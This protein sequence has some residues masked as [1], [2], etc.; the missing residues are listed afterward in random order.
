MLVPSS[1]AAGGA[2]AP[3]PEAEDDDD[4][5]EEGSQKMPPPPDPLPVSLEDITFKERLV[6]RL[7]CCGIYA[8]QETTTNQARRDAVA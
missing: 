7:L 5:D 3:A 2:S 6:C 1:T 4:D 8:V